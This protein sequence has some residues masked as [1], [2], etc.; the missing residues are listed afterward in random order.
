MAIVRHFKVS[1][2]GAIGLLIGLIWSAGC[3]DNAAPM[4][5]ALETEHFVIMQDDGLSEPCGALGELF[6]RYYRAFESYLELHR[7][8]TKKITYRQFNSFQAARNACGGGAATVIYPTATRWCRSR[9]SI[10]TRLPTS[11]KHSSAAPGPRQ[12]CLRK[13][14]RPRCLEAWNTAETTIG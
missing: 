14:W 2:L 4:R 3:G 10:H 13:A 7:S 11:S 1:Y 8:T 9:Q 12:R 5:V 6:E